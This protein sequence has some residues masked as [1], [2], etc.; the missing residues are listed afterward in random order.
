MTV[1][2]LSASKETRDAVLANGIEHGAAESCDRWRRGWE[3]RS[4]CL[5][6]GCSG[7][8]VPMSSMLHPLPFLQLC[9]DCLTL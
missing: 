2:V 7:A 6:D 3:V 4:R 1:T 5:F 9:V 8:T